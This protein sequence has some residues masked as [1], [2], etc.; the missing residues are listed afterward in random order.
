MKYKNINAFYHHFQSTSGSLMEGNDSDSS[1]GEE[2]DKTQNLFKQQVNFFCQM[3]DFLLSQQM[4][5]KQQ[6][7]MLN[8][9]L[10]KKRKPR[11]ASRRHHQRYVPPPSSSIHLP[12]PEKTDSSSSVPDKSVN[13][14]IQQFFSCSST[15]KSG[16][17]FHY[18]S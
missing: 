12:I 8:S 9:N 1:S 13:D 16:K 10:V 2:R 5:L 14:N 7:E 3:K 18:S 4:S 17:I 6:L 15:D 11:S